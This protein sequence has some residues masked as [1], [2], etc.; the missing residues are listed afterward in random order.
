MKYL[1]IAVIIFVVAWRW[2]SA[3]TSDKLDARQKRAERQPTDMVRCAQCGIHLPAQE[4]IAG[5]NGSY[6]SHEHRQL[7][8]S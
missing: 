8:E 3:R 2:R 7:T 6:C 4:A 1:L 5:R